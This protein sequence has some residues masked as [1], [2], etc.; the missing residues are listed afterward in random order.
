MSPGQTD[1]PQ[2][3]TLAAAKAWSGLTAVTLRKYIADGRIEATRSRGR[4]GDAW[5]IDAASLAAFVLAQYGRELPPTLSHPVTP[6]HENV[7]DP[8]TKDDLYAR[9]VELTEEVGRYK[10]L[11][12]SAEAT[13][14]RVEAGLRTTIVELRAERDAARA[15]AEAKATEAESARAE[16]A[17]RAAEVTRLQARGFWARLLNR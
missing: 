2:T 17:E 3:L 5:A 12:A 9:I 15:A 13:N 8:V 7:S 6:G 10:A 14:E 4:H 1:T 11:A 16:A